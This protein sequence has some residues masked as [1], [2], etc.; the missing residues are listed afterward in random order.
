MS[1]DHDHILDYKGALW[2]DAHEQRQKLTSDH[3]LSVASFVRRIEDAFISLQGGKRKVSQLAVAIINRNPELIDELLLYTPDNAVGGGGSLG[4]IISCIHHGLTRGLCDG[5]FIEHIA[6]P[7]QRRVENTYS[8]RVKSDGKAEGINKLSRSARD[9]AKKAIKKHE[10]IRGFT[11]DEWF[12][13]EDNSIRAITIMKR[14]GWIFDHKISIHMGLRIRG[15]WPGFP[16]SDGS[17]EAFLPS[18]RAG[19]ARW[20]VFLDNRDF[21]D[22]NLEDML[23]FRRFIVADATASS[24][25]VPWGG[26]HGASMHI[27][28]SL[29]THSTVSLDTTL[30]ECV[31]IDSRGVC[32]L[33]WRFDNIWQAATQLSL[34]ALSLWDMCMQNEPMA[35]SPLF[36][37]KRIRF[38]LQTAYHGLTSTAGQADPASL[39]PLIRSDLTLAE[40]LLGSAGSLIQHNAV[41]S[42]EARHIL[43]VKFTG[44]I[45]QLTASTSFGCSVDTQL[46]DGVPEEDDEEVK[47]LKFHQLVNTNLHACMVEEGWVFVKESGSVGAGLI[48]VRARRFIP[49]YGASN[50]QVIAYFP[51]HLNNG[52]ALYHLLHDDNDCEDVSFPTLLEAMDFYSKDI[53]ESPDALSDD[54]DDYD[55]EEESKESIFGKRSAIGRASRGQV[56]DHAVGVLSHNAVFSRRGRQILPRKMLEVDASQMTYNSEA[57]ASRSHNRIHLGRATD[58][59]SL[60][61]SAPSQPN[62]RRRIEELYPVQSSCVGE[63]FQ[64]DVPPFDARTIF[65]DPDFDWARY[66]GLFADRQWEV[67][68]T[69]ADRVA[70][71]SFLEQVKRVLF[72]IG[73]IFSA[74]VDKPDIPSFQDTRMESDRRPIEQFAPNSY[75]PVPE[76]MIFVCC[77]SA[78]DE[79]TQSVVVES[80]SGLL[81]VPLSRCVSFIQEDVLSQIWRFYTG[82][83][84]H[85]EEAIL[86]AK[87]YALDIRD[88]QWSFPEVKTYFTARS[89]FG[90]DLGKLHRQ[91][92]QITIHKNESLTKFARD[93]AM[94]TTL[95]PQMITATTGHLPT[96]TV[97]DVVR[98][99]HWFFP[100]K[101]SS[102][103]SRQRKRNLLKVFSVSTAILADNRTYDESLWPT[104][105]GFRAQLESFVG[106]DASVLV[107]GELLSED[108]DSDKDETMGDNHTLAEQ[109]DRDHPIVLD[110][111]EVQLVDPIS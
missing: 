2:L 101:L 79:G 105:E 53:I 15:C 94:T 37:D 109:N 57:V 49:G 106:V 19:G 26:V 24:L 44:Y 32:A 48:G 83:S 1:I 51:P 71:E 80:G 62:K 9:K 5:T 30:V 110:D 60:D 56:S 102:T 20:R 29:Q 54:E 31:E 87:H 98:F 67:Q 7:S 35:D 4:G 25:C 16:H 52:E 46:N 13:D 107:D 58:L 38:R 103:S 33:L 55:E 69:D 99:H 72:P 59:I 100:F 21:I 96:R 42:D 66:V 36:H 8:L 28:Q 111:D 77:V 12:D 27:P 91:M 93:L 40:L 34:S 64:A 18:Y 74:I 86:A 23:S 75:P 61:M 92:T 65:L 11:L 90:D 43:N 41:I 76:R 39:A 88:K 73:C 95:P 14:K 85:I 63:N 22:L 68:Q 47:A 17:V 6:E 81:V 45:Q 50:A 82:S 10:T 84:M 70:F 97:Q 104:P 108:N 89:S 78:I 3:P